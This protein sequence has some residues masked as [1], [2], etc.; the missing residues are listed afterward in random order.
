MCATSGCAF[1][2]AAT[3]SKSFGA[4][5][6]AHEN[7]KLWLSRPIRTSW[8]PKPF[9]PL[10][11]KARPNKTTYT[12]DTLSYG[13]EQ[14][15][16]GHVF[17]AH[18]DGDIVVLFPQSRVLAAGDMYTEGAATPQLIDYRGGGSAKQWTATVAE[19]LK[20]DFD[21]VVPGHGNVTTKREMTAFRDSTQRLTE[22][23]T[24]LVKQGKSRAEIEQ[25]MRME[26]GWQ[27]L[28]VQLAL[29]GLINEMQ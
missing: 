15:D 12:T 20:L 4:T 3:R 8:L 6:I 24:Q 25:T 18:T 9:G 17:Q 23:A 28:H 16:Y 10:P 7:T 13:G 19:V 21:T 26:F 27:D 11:E 14:I 2:S 29:D 5:L 1:T 22:L